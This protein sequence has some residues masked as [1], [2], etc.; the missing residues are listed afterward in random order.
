MPTE[1]F[2]RDYD[3]EF[4][5]YVEFRCSTCCKSHPELRFLHLK[6]ECKDRQV[7][8]RFGPRLAYAVLQ[9][10][11]KYGHDHLDAE[12]GL[13]I[14][15]SQL[16]GCFPDAALQARK[17]LQ[18]RRECLR[19]IERLESY[20]FPEDIL[21]RRMPNSELPPRRITTKTIKQRWPVVPNRR[22]A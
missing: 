17:T 12:K 2:L 20:S 9:A 6:G 5:G 1:T 4:T 8:H 15:Q 18:S 13:F 21:Q 14:T 22:S 11:L 3:P 7:T 16:E 10:S 19:A